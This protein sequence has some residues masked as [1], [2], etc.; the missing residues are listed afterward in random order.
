MITRGLGCGEVI[1]ETIDHVFSLM[2]T[3]Y[4]MPKD[5]TK[6]L[7]IKTKGEAYSFNISTIKYRD[8]KG[9]FVKFSARRKLK[10]EVYAR[11]ILYNKHT[12]KKEY[13]EKRIRKYTQP[14]AKR[15]K[16][17]T[18]ES[19]NKR[20]T[21]KALLKNNKLELIEGKDGLIRFG[22]L[23]KEEQKQKQKQKR[24]RKKESKIM[25]GSIREFIQSFGIT[26]KKNP[27]S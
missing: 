24:T 1:R 23:S 2:Y 15:K 7:E 13:V 4:S 17:T 12:N 9:R 27:T 6:Y 3:T 25:R 8:K 14:Y 5:K 11:R 19:V 26:L 10:V 16:P 21:K 18:I 20:L 22:Y